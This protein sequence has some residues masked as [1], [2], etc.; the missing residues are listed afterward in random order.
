MKISTLAVSVFATNCYLAYDSRTGEGVIIDPGDEGDRIKDEVT[1]LKFTP[2]GIL[3]THGHGD[4]IGAV[5]DMKAEYDVPIYA[6]PNAEKVIR[7]SN[8][9]FF[10]A[11]GLDVICPMP[12][13]TV[14]E[15]ETVSF[16]ECTLRVIETP[17]HSIDA[18]CF[19]AGHSLFC[20]DTIFFNSIGRTD[21][22]G[23][24]FDQLI[25]S[26][27]EKLMILPDETVC[28][29]GHGPRTTI[30]QERENNPFLIGSF[31]D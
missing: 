23:G 30:G 19:L 8:K 16:G 31:P 11:V 10:S 20:G 25:D 21:L 27:T 12:D 17:G 28:Y 4:H 22:A 9:E 5:A 2:V 18:I 24:N 13:I 6:G 7:Y 15:D 3:I 26:I 14:G 29:T 1:R